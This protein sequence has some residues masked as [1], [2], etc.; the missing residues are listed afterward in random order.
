[1]VPSAEPGFQR[2]EAPHSRALSRLALVLDFCEINLPLPLSILYSL[3]GTW[4]E[5]TETL[6]GWILKCSSFP[7]TAER[8]RGGADGLGA[9]AWSKATLTSA[10]GQR[11]GTG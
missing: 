8:Y 9:P 7:G 3:P 2:T 4:E 1:M 11:G 6:Q 10:L 5:G